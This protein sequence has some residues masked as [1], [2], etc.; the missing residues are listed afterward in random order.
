MC[1]PHQP[2]HAQKATVAVPLSQQPCSSQ[3]PCRPAQ[4]CLFLIFKSSLLWASL[5]LLCCS[6]NNEHSLF[7]R[8]FHMWESAWNIPSRSTRVSSF[9]QSGSVSRNTFSEY[10]TCMAQPSSPTN[11]CFLP[12]DAHYHD[13]VHHA[14]DSP[15]CFLLR[16]GLNGEG[17]L[18]LFTAVSP[19]SRISMWQLFD[20]CQ[21]PHRHAQKEI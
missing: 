1:E 11:S 2:S 15:V 6:L 21:V 14:A 18:V 4:V 16:C 12:P 17:L 8:S 9:T 20:T 7:S 5:T 19:E 10:L 3:G 13:F